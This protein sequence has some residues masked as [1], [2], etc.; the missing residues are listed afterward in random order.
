MVTLAATSHAAISVYPPH[1]SRT[2]WFLL[3]VCIS[4]N[5]NLEFS[6]KR[7]RRLSDRWTPSFSLCVAMPMKEG[8]RPPVISEDDAEAGDAPGR[9]QVSSSGRQRR[10]KGEEA[11][12]MVLFI[13][14]FWAAKIWK[15]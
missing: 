5:F 7:R 15:I 1:L 3:L 14:R 4:T 9:F 11:L 2:L 12:V 13:A 8:R 10:E 6:R